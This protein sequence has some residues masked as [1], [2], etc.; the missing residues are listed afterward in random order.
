[1]MTDKQ[2]GRDRADEVL[3]SPAMGGHAAPVDP[4]LS[5]ATPAATPGPQPATILIRRCNMT[6]EPGRRV[7]GRSQNAIN[8]PALVVQP[9]PPPGPVRPLT[10]LDGTSIRV[11]A[12]DPSKGV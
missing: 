2:P 10:T 12:L 7:I 9:A 8:A 1:V 4:E 6:S 5:V 3:V 11:H